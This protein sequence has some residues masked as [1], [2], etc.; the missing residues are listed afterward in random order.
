MDGLDAGGHGLAHRLLPVKV[1]SVEDEAVARRLRGQCAERALRSHQ[2]IVQGQWCGPWVTQRHTTQ[3]RDEVA[4]ASQETL[5]LVR[6]ALYDR[7]FDALKSD[8]KRRV[9]EAPPDIPE[10]EC[11]R[12]DYPD[13][14][15]IHSAAR[16][17]SIW[18]TRAHNCDG[19]AAAA[20]DMLAHRHPRLP[21][22]SLMLG[23]RHA[24][25]VVGSLTPAI[26]SRPM[27]SWPAHLQVCDPWANLSCRACDYPARFTEKMRK[28]ALH[29]KRIY[30]SAEGWH[31]PLD[32]A[33]LAI[34]H[35]RPEVLVRRRH[36]NGQ[37]RDV[38]MPVPGGR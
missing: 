22:C 14:A 17:A 33:W 16:S 26:A 19:L 13:S 34:V 21:T 6:L 18:R 32:P 12:L 30:G 1:R 11:A 28:W 37:F 7:R 31:S 23:E 29:G 24:L 25:A 9:G 4:R 35:E 27:A 36:R 5:R 15:P 3:V 8:N 20:L 10:E 2:R 38:S